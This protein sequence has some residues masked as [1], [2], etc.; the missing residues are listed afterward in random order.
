MEIINGAPKS[1]RTRYWALYALQP[2]QSVLYGPGE[3][4]RGG[5][6]ASI[7]HAQHAYRRR[8]TV[9]TQPDGGIR[10]WRLDD[11]PAVPEDR[12]FADRDVILG[13]DPYAVK[14][15]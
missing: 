11:R 9:R 15:P 3:Y 12:V 14:E 5:L 2:N 6:R 10:V 4:S 1:T 7:T 13:G 8:F